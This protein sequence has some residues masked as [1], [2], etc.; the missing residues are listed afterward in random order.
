MDH[1]P[2]LCINR[3]W[4]SQ[5][6]LMVRKSL[7]VTKAIDLFSYK[8]NATLELSYHWVIRRHMAGSLGDFVF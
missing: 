3:H 4:F 5:L 6:K 2:K 1:P 8:Q 7:F